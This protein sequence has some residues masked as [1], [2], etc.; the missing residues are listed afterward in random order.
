MQDDR[1]RFAIAILLLIATWQVSLEVPALAS[2]WSL[3]L[4]GSDLKSPTAESL[5]AAGG[6]GA[7]GSEARTLEK[8]LSVA[9]DHS[10]WSEERDV[11]ELAEAIYRESVAAEVDPLMVTAIVARESS[12]RRAAVSRAGAVGLMQL[13]PF[14]ARDVARRSGVEWEGMQTLQR[15]EHNLRLGITYYREM[16][17]RFDGDLHLA[18][19][20]YNR[21]PTRITREL[22]AGQAVR[23]RYAE[24]VLGLYEE[25]SLQT[26]GT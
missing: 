18:L 10:R 11:G 12:F 25:L 5:R 15:P 2:A 13:R 17:E 19:A 3:A 20:A 6:G 4:T 23:S 14:V 9:R 26:R 24:R 16:V 8:I 22:R 1:A 21:G 7:G